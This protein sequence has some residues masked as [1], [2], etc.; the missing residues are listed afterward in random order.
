MALPCTWVIT[1]LNTPCTLASTVIIIPLIVIPDGS[2]L[3]LLDPTF[4][5]ID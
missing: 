5:S 1:D 2:S 4:S 3:M